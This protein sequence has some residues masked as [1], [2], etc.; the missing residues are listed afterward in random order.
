MNILHLAHRI[1]YPPN[2]GDKLRAFRQ[3]QHLARSHRVTAAFF[4]DDPEDERH[5]AGLRAH[6]YRVVVIRIHKRRRMIHGMIRWLGGGTITEGFYDVAAMRRAL[7]Q[8]TREIEFD[9]ILAF[10]SS[11]AA[12]ALDVPAR[13]HVLDLCDLDS[14]KWSDYARDAR[15][16]MRWIYRAEGTRL[17]RRERHWAGAF[18]ATVLITRAEVEALRCEDAERQIHVI[19]NGVTLP[20]PHASACAISPPEPH[21]SACAISPS[22]EHL[23]PTVGFVGQ[24]NYLPNV[25]AVCFFARQCWPG[26]KRVM[27]D[28]RFRIIGRCPTRVVRRLE[29]IAGIEVAGAVDDIHAEL[30]RIDVSVA[31]LRIARGLQN[32]VLEA[33]VAAKPVVLTPAAATGIDA[34]DGTEFV[35][36]ADA[37]SFTD[38]VLGLLADKTLRQR[39]GLAGR[40]FAQTHH[41]W[42]REMARLEAI[43]TEDAEPTTTPRSAATLST[44]ATPLEVPP[45]PAPSPEGSEFPLLL[46]GGQGEGRDVSQTPASRRIAPARPLRLN[47]PPRAICSGSAILGMQ[48]RQT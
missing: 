17:A 29:S 31:P 27:P 40:R 38:R 30:R 47:V 2:K 24:M 33:M 34:R 45:S 39:I 1:P 20:E 26:I 8:L 5:V 36:A 15:P 43:L 48:G 19:T 22:Q 41:D 4:V 25:D 11:M 21:A 3:I 14:A 23:A 10:S 44:T 7:A 6:C 37:K 9:A 28:A 35:I 42:T 16:P 13:R 12:F 32:K 18:D 46:G